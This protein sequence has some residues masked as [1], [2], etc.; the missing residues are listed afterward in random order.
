LGR[1]SEEMKDTLKELLNECLK[2]AKQSKGG[3]DPNKYPSQVYILCFIFQ[4]CRTVHV[5]SLSMKSNIINNSS[6]IGI[7]PF[8]KDKPNHNK[9][10]LKKVTILI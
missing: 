3:L 6:F 10:N 4:Q 1:L 9:A 7:V 5:Y 2:D 8:A